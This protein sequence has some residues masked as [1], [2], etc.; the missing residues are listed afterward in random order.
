MTDEEG[1]VTTYVNDSRGRPTSITQAAGRPEAQQ[2]TITWHGMFNVPATVAKPG[3]TTS[4]AYNTS[5]QLTSLTQTDTT[6]HA[7]PYATNGQSRTWTFTYGSGGLVA[8][9]DGPLA[10]AGDTVSYSYDAAGYVAFFTDEVGNVTTVNAVNGRGQ[11]TDISDANGLVSELTYDARGRLV[12][13]VDDPSGFAA[14]TQLDYDNAG[15]VT[16]LTDPDGAV[17]VMTYDGSNRLATVTNAQGDVASYG[18][19]AMGNRTTEQFSNAAAQL[20]F[21]NVRTF[22]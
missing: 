19:D 22:D 1:R 20:V 6:T 10:G 21:E 17:L 7:L 8:S 13:K 15:N 5:G 18:Y 4:Y 2:T 9:I 11:P 3:L 14:Q 16:R 12:A